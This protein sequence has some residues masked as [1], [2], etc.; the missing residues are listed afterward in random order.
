MARGLQLGSAVGEE[1]VRRPSGARS[2]T[3]L[4]VHVEGQ[5]EEHFV[6]ELLRPHLVA[7]GFHEVS[8]R[9]LGNVRLRSGRGGIRP[10]SSAR[11]DIVTQMRRDE[12]A[13][14]TTMV[15]F[16]AL[17]ASGTAEW[18]GRQLANQRPTV[19]HKA[20]AVE[21]GMMREVADAVGEW[22]ASR[23]FVPFVLMHEFEALL[24]SD[25]S[26]FASAIGSTS[27]LA[28]LE[29][30]RNAFASPEHINDSP[31]T[32]PSKRLE[33]AIGGYQKTLHGI[34]GALGIGI[35][36]MRSACPHFAAW[37]SRLEKLPSV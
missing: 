33:R 14:S 29:G 22:T 15:D 21:D 4:F 7:R 35:E 10:W 13:A 11:K 12:T 27:Q 37:L 5:T 26:A 16:Y 25:C 20:Q 8:A 2:M 36:G 32:A 28:T 3:R 1:R 19:D 6:T 30:V 34:L 9:I 23:R 24:F 18:P 31:I 17:P